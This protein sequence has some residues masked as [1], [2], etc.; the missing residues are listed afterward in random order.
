MCENMNK[1]KKY[2]NNSFLYTKLSFED[3]NLKLGH[4]T[5]D[6]WFTHDPIRCEEKSVA[7]PGAPLPSILSLVCKFDIKEVCGNLSNRFF[8]KKLLGQ[9]ILGK[10]M[11]YKNS[12]PPINHLIP[13]R[14]M[15][16]KLDESLAGRHLKSPGHHLV[17]PYTWPRSPNGHGHDLE[18]SKVK[19]MAKVKH[20]GH[21]WGLEFNRCVCFACRG[22]RTNCIWDIA[23]S[24]FDLG[25]SRSRS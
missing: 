24:I 21:T 20:I 2:K 7:K 18:N 22:N 5:G 15:L 9:K 1:G 25:N 17:D 12:F 13:S 23:N 6:K 19:V 16:L 8:V 3:L 14:T 10:W 11:E 4:R